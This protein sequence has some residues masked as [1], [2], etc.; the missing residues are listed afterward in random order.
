MLALHFAM[1]GGVALVASRGSGV[2]LWMG[3][4][5]RSI[6]F[7][8][9]LLVE[10]RRHW[11]GA[12]MYFVARAVAGGLI[13]WGRKGDNIHC[14]WVGIVLK[15]GVPP[16]HVWVRG[17]ARVLSTPG[18]LFSFLFTVKLGPIWVAGW[19]GP[20]H[21]WGTQLIFSILAI[22]GAMLGLPAARA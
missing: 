12:A 1:A 10:A 7:L 4:Q 22:A 8:G 17:V 18:L 19:V 3:L 11:T 13:Y 16:L 6:G 20:P 9:L 15:L 5:L 14:L 2:Y 21:G